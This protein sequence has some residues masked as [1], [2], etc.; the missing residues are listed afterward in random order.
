MM[1]AATG[2]GST[3]AVAD[4]AALR[5]EVQASLFAGLPRHVERLRWN[6]A[7]IR[8]FQRD[9]LRALLAH[10]IARSPFYARRLSGVDP[11][12]FELDQLPGLPVMTKADMMAEFGDV[13]TDRRLTRAVVEDSLAATGSEARVLLGRYFCLA[14][15]GSSG[16]RGVFVSDVPAMTEFISLLMRPAIARMATV[17]RPGAGPA[18]ATRP[19]AAAPPPLTIGFVAAASPVHATGLVSRLMA[20]SPATFIPVPVTLRLAEIVSRLNDAQPP[21]L[22][23]YPSMLARL[24]R[25]Q[26]AGRLRIAPTSITCTSET[27]LPEYRAAIAAGFAVPIVNSF[28]S[29]EGLVGV[30][31]PDT[32]AITLASD[33][34]ITEF[35]DERD[36]PVPPGTASAKILVTNLY[37]HVQPLI[38]YEMGDSCTRLPESPAHGHTLATVDGRADE[39]LHYAAA[40]VHPLALRSVLVTG[41]GI[42]DY[43][44]RQTRAGIQ[45]SVLRDAPADLAVLRAGLAGA[46]ADAGLPDPEVTVDVVAALPCNPETGKLRRFIPA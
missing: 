9:R 46:L 5:D 37:N 45:V 11:A 32:E 8:R 44:V 30:S 6:A 13:V 15:G 1:R 21:L 17:G 43:Q 2:R 4:F 31:D 12:R 40:D 3:H 10:A 39:I 19:P 35:V 22:Y 18:D 25:E 27:L 23:G 36:R 28:G 41:R 38:R 33:G 29:T 34:C 26:Q 7:Q 20:G 14:T 24:A 16:R 42:A